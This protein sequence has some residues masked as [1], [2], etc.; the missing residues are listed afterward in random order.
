MKKKAPT[1]DQ[2]ISIDQVTTTAQVTTMEQP[3]PP[4]EREPLLDLHTPDGLKL[5]KAG[6][7]VYI[8]SETKAG[9]DKSKRKESIYTC[10]Y[11]PKGS[12]T[13]RIVTLVK[14]RIAYFQAKV[15]D[16][17]WDVKRGQLVNPRHV[18]GFGKHGAILFHAYELNGHCS[19]KR[20]LL[21]H[22]Q[23]MLRALRSL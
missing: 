17:F 18:E 12:K 8:R 16:R 20:T 7:V 2:I 15:A 3:P 21:G 19:V 23:K 22:F 10:A 1:T 13:V 9:K 4:E 14:Q 6:Q 5:V 11:Y